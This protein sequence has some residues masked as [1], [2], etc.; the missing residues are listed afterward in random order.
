MGRFTY[1]LELLLWTEFV[2]KENMDLVKKAKGLGFDGV[3]IFLNEPDRFPVEETKRALKENGM[4]VGFAVCLGKDTN[5]ISPD[6]GVRKAGIGF[7]KKC[8][9]T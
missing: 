1:G 2:R 6:A 3:E 7:F 8:K 5:I 9:G 4:K